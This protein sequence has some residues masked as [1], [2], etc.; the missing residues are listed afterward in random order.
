MEP[1]IYPGDVVLIQKMLK[2]EDIEGLKEGDIINFQRGT[3]TITHRIEEILRDE[4]GNLSFVT[5]GDNNKSRDEQ[6]VLPNDVKGII[7]QVVPKVGIPILWVKSGNTVPEGV[8]DYE[9]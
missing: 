5:K 1:V 2:E 9:E 7:V 3:I 8:I 4:A 6:V